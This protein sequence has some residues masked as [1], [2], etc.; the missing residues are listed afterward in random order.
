VPIPIAVQVLQ[1]P[2][3][4]NEGIAQG[5]V[6]IPMSRAIDMKAVG[7]DLRTGDD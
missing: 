7:V 5:K 6:Y 4:I 1:L 3:G 2:L